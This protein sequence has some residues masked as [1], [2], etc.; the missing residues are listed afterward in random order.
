[1]TNSAELDF[2]LSV[3]KPY[4][5]FVKSGLGLAPVPLNDVSKFDREVPFTPEHVECPLSPTVPTS[6]RHRRKNRTND[7]EYLVSG[8]LSDEEPSSVSSPASYNLFA[9]PKPLRGGSL[10][11]YQLEGVSWMARLHHC[12]LNGILADEMGLG[13]TIQT[14]GFIAYLQE[15]FSIKGPHLIVVPKST[16]P[17]WLRELKKWL[18]S[19]KAAGLI[20][21]KEERAEFIHEHFNGKRTNLDVLV[22]TYE[23]CSI[24]KT[25]IRKVPWVLLA[26]DEAHRLKSCESKI[27]E[28]LRSFH[29]KRRLLLTGTPL[30]NNLGELWS[31]LNFLRPDVFNDVELFLEWFNYESE[32]ESSE[33]TSNLHSILKPFV[34]RRV[35]S[36]V[37][38]LPP[39][40]ETLVH[41]QL[42]QLQK[43][44]YK[45]IITRELPDILRSVD[46]SESRSKIGLLNV[47]MQLKKACN[48]PYL[49]DGIEPG[50]PFVEG[51]H[52]VDSCGKLRV[53]DRLLLKLEREG[54]KV[55]I[56]SQMTRLLD[57]LE[58]FCSLRSYSYRR[59]DG[60]TDTGAREEA[61]EEFQ[62][63]GSDV[64][65]F[66]LSTRAGGLGI[67]LTAADTVVLYDSDWNPQADLQAIDRAH[68]IGQKRPVRVFRFVSEATV[69]EKILE[70]AMFKLQLDA[71]V[72]Q[73]GR[74]SDKM[75]STNKKDLLAMV[76]F[77]ADRVFNQEG[78]LSDE[79]IDLLLAK[80]EERTRDISSKIKENCQK[81]LEN[82]D[83][84]MDSSVSYTQV[85]GI[86]IDESE[87]LDEIRS[88]APD[89]F[90][91][92]R[93]EPS[94]R[95]ATKQLPSFVATV[96]HDFQFFPPE[97]EALDQK[98]NAKLKYDHDLANGLLSTS[99]EPPEW[100]EDD[101]QQWNVCFN[102]GFPN[103]SRTDFNKFVKGLEKFGHLREN[104]N[105][106]ADHVSSKTFEEVELFY[107]AFWK[108]FKSLSEAVRIQKAI[109][110]AIEKRIRADNFE[111]ILTK[112]IAPF[113]DDWKGTEL[114]G[115]YSA[116][117]KPKFTEVED[118]T[119]LIAAA[120]NGLENW[121]DA[122]EEIRSR[123]EFRF[124][125]FIRSR[126]VNEIARRT[127]QLLRQIE[128]NMDCGKKRSSK[129]LSLVDEDGKKPRIEEKNSGKVTPTMHS[130][131]SKK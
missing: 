87:F 115:T 107:D 54:S 3:L 66:L 63:D 118:R 102:Q 1:M 61:V 41:V 76:R 93:T 15:Q 36:D 70:R 30:Q 48:H 69:E 21:T 9:Q 79:D 109:N 67:N 110:K 74:I 83:L 29:S 53:L 23:V 8:V 58:D 131:V 16:L 19:A 75:K 4:S 108:N 128:R 42:T 59:L 64:F 44:I 71:L 124:N 17:N 114:K 26:V 5:H 10:R 77:G 78:E 6:R 89:A 68:R 22:T 130:F 91:R 43:G 14:I 105:E 11:T 51:E 57:I 55:L 62:K 80:S 85:S 60:S 90:T 82:L 117:Y 95:E 119:L 20:G 88:L 123:P 127:E 72:I 31:L 92:R 47:M 97:F 28:V 34:L 116:S 25:A 121:D 7:D 46:G 122:T 100:T 45:S 33:I 120:N 126:P 56:F 40:T 2:V 38:D 96:R 101:E 24:E 103:W 113:G 32:I 99:T 35:K 52:L 106:V 13:K 39:K 111:V 65:V 104:L 112:K 129:M 86:D 81:T 18:P 73:Q 98:R 94:G 37:E 27:S 49:F 84:S 50:P 125:W 12:N